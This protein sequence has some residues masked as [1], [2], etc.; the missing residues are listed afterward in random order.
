MSV[1]I[2]K[3]ILQLGTNVIHERVVA[4]GAK[5]PLILVHGLGVSGDYYLPFAEKMKAFYDIYIIDLPGYGKTPKPYPPLTI[6]ELANV[7]LEYIATKNISDAV[8]IGQSMGCQIVAQAAARQ[9]QRF[10]KLIL[11]S[12]TVNQF[13]RT[14]L[15]QSLRLVQD[16]LREPPS[17]VFI[18]L[19]DYLRMGLRRYLLTTKSMLADH[20]EETL[21]KCPQPVLVVRGKKDTIVPH[22]WAAV[23][24]E[25]KERTLV[26][27]QD[28]PHLL[29]YKK[30]RELVAICRQFIES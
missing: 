7:L 18:V 22:R 8:A 17:V 25:N 21:T 23:L 10:Q 20:I 19:R 2:K 9:P 30:P 6:D 29:Q 5:T 27:M 28:A 3:T 15:T 11:L 12:P 4:S 16:T 24:T 14:F 1:A 26:E 13:E